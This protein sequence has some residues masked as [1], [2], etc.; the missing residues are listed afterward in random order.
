MNQ[1]QLSHETEKENLKDLKIH[2]YIMLNR[3]TIIHIQISN[4]KRG[5]T[6]ETRKEQRNPKSMLVLPLRIQVT[7]YLQSHPPGRKKRKKEKKKVG[8][9]AA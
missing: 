5:R 1:N 4:L 3:R 7:V 6:K 9:E 2:I 8:S